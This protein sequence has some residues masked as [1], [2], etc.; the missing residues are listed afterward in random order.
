MVN[1]IK[2]FVASFIASRTFR[3]MG[4]KD[5]SDIMM[6]V[7]WLSLA[8]SIIIFWGNISGMKF[9]WSLFDKIANLF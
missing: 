4:K 5:F 3:A 6:L 1:G 9:L 2:I 7:G 8:T